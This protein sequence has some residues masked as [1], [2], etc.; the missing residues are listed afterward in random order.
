ML[1]C[2]YLSLWKPWGAECLGIRDMCCNEVTG[3]GRES[4]DP[5]VGQEMAQG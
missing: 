2:P 3:K 1:H 5:Q 4:P